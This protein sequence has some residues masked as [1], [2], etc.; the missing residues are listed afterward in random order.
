MLPDAMLGT[1]AIADANAALAYAECQVKQAGVVEAYDAVV[2]A[3][4]ENAK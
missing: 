3:L 2:A 4:S 1:L